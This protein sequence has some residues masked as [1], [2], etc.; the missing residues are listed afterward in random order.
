MSKLIYLDYAAAT[1]VAPEVLSAMQP[2]WSDEFYNP[3][4]TYLAAKQVHVAIEQARSEV[5]MILG[6]RAS[7]VIFTAGATEAN[8]LA[9]Q[10]IMNQYPGKN[11]VISNMEH[12][13][14]LELAHRYTCFEASVNHDGVIVLSDLENVVDDQTVLISIMYANNEVGT[15]QPIK[16]IAALIARELRKRRAS[17]NDLPLIFHTDATQAAN[18]L[19]LHVSRLGVDLMTLNGGKIY[20][21]KQTGALYVRSGVVLQPVFYGGGQEHNLRSGTENVAG[22]VGFAKA[23]TLTQHLRHEEV[24]RL[25]TLQINFFDM[26]AD[27]VPQAI[28]NGSRKYRLPN[29]IHISL[30]GEDNERLLMALDEVGIMAAA[31]S[32]CMA[33]DEEPSHVLRALGV[34]SE[35]AQSTLRFTMGRDTLPTSISYTVDAL[36]RLIAKS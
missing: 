9:L 19:D 32:A 5:A 21:P 30:P 7:E 14:I 35:D 23:L 11:I 1:P 22:I 10:G 26:L 12:A 28:V 6:A 17:N 8:N 15:I 36:A 25:H 16:A 31:G 24:S 4:A 3:S 18:Y 34:S 33:S 29:N 2:Y 20:G 13:S 27:K